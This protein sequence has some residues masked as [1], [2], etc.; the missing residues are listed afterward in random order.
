ML[1]IM[2]PQRPPTTP[3][4][5]LTMKEAAQMP[6]HSAPSTLLAQDM[7]RTM[8]SSMTGA[9]ASRSWQTCLEEKRIKTFCILFISLSLSLCKRHIDGLKMQNMRLLYF[10]LWSGDLNIMFKV[11]TGKIALLTC[12]HKGKIL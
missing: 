4:W 9:H 8:T 1:R 2:T 7:T 5:C 12:K 11:G 3:S 10:T 6:V